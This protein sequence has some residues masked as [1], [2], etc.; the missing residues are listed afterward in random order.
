VE[1]GYI[2]PCRWQRSRQGGFLNIL[3]IT[4]REIW[5]I[6]ENETKLKSYKN[7][8]ETKLNF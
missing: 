8:Y 5:N 2:Y 4:Y 7:K 1:M 3:H 6:T